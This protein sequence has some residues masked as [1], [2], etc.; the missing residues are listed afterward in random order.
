M[1]LEKERGSALL[2]IV[3][4]LAV[5]TVAG[6]AYSARAISVVKQTA[7]TLQADQAYACAEAGA[8]EAL[9]KIE[10]GEDLSAC[11]VDSPCSGS[12]SKAESPTETL[13]Q[14][15]YYSSDDPQSGDTYDF[16]LEQDQTVQLFLN[17]LSGGEMVTLNWY[18]AE[19]D[20]GAAAILYSLIYSDGGEYQVVKDL[21]DPE[22]RVPD[23]DCLPGAG[24]GDWEHS[25]TLT[26]PAGAV[27]PIFLRVRALFTSNQAQIQASGLPSQGIK[28][29][30]TG[31]AGESVRRVEVKRSHPY[32][33]TIF[34][35]VLFSGSETQP[36]TK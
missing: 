35:Y 21:V 6:L 1:P 16:T 7:R 5:L 10:A 25:L 15:S 23:A 31:Y 26:V 3:G 11:L 36:L 12:L 29:V 14:F 33:P 2:I 28:I 34:D 20:T 19:V 22:C 32:L 17:G 27:D 8:E 4:V 30:S 13:C 18:N 24:A 9:G